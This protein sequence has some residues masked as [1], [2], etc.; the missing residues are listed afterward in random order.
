MS[1]L[2]AA[3]GMFQHAAKH[4]QNGLPQHNV[5]R[6]RS[7]SHGRLW[8]LPNISTQAQ[9]MHQTSQN[10]CRLSSPLYAALS[11]MQLHLRTHACQLRQHDT[12]RLLRH[13]IMPSRRARQARL[14]NP[15]RHPSGAK[16]DSLAQ[17]LSLLCSITSKAQGTHRT[18]RIQPRSKL[19]A[20]SR[21]DQMTLQVIPTPNDGCRSRNCESCSSTSNIGTCRPVIPTRRQQKHKVCGG[22]KIAHCEHVSRE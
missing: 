22:S 16:D 3:P 19:V 12:T 5:T 1:T 18:S 11:S 21:P 15:S 4:V 8:D 14:P 20:R 7:S 17:R 2:A 10:Y 6:S 9:H 13:Q